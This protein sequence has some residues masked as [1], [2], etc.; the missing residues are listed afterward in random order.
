[1]YFSD[2]ETKLIKV[3]ICVRNLVNIYFSKK[4]D[5][6]FVNTEFNTVFAFEKWHFT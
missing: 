5:N 1:M 2:L 6:Q 4:H 3:V